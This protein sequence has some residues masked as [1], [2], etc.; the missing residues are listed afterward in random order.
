MKREL[1]DL[2]S[3]KESTRAKLAII[4]RSI[5]RRKTYIRKHGLRKVRENHFEN[6]LKPSQSSENS[7]SEVPIPPVV[8]PELS[9]ILYPKVFD[10]KTT[11][12]AIEGLIAYCTTT[13]T[14]HHNSQKMEWITCG[15]GA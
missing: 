8:R 9:N 13:S 11:L 6:L 5:E 10:S 15:K 3:Q 2:P 1:R 14:L 12:L 7:E 4:R